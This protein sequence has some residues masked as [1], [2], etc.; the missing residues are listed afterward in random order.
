MKLIKAQTP[1]YYQTSNAVPSDQEAASSDR[2]D[3]Q[4]SPKQ[5]ISA[6]TPESESEKESPI[7]P[8]RHPNYVPPVDRNTDNG[9]Q[10][11]G[12]MP[13]SWFSK[14]PP[15]STPETNGSGL[16]PD[17]DLHTNSQ[18][19]QGTQPLEELEDLE[20]N[21]KPGDDASDIPRDWD[22]ILPDPWPDSLVC[23]HADGDTFEIGRL[24]GSVYEDADVKEVQ[25]YM[26]LF[27]PPFV[28]KLINDE[29]AGFPAIFYAVATNDVGMVRLFLRYGADASAVHGPSQTPLLAFAIAYGEILQEDTTTIVS[30]LLCN[31][32]SPHVIPAD[33]F[34][35]YLRDSSGSSKSGDKEEK[36]KTELTQWC[37]D[38]ARAQLMKAANI[39]QRYYLERA[40]KLKKP[41]R[42]RQQVARLRNA[43]NLLGIPYFL[44]GQ[45]V[46]TDMLIQRLLTHLMMPTKR[47]LVLCFA[48]PSGH[49]KTELARQLGHLLSLDLEVVDCTIVKREMELFGPRQPY[50]GAERGSPVNNFL[51]SHS[52]QRCIVFFDEFEKTTKEIHQALLL[53]FD[54]GRS[55]WR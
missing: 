44:V 37:T 13:D 47:P 7:G 1:E 54:N 49:G 29:V 12:T 17:P 10:D 50:I 55:R 39:S 36:E 40:T 23:H 24:V 30:T 35:P 45:P 32:A 42:K 48:G 53:P 27:D 11:R 22:F 20:L 9:P 33:I 51:A 38:A 14:A 18:V 28:K 2:S 4:A 26:E 31:G 19:L 21:E 16:P 3:S 5:P 43:E 6:N 15:G 46:A 25:D 8:Y 34:T 52:R 41:S